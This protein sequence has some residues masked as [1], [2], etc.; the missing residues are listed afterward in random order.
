MSTSVSNNPT[1]SIGESL[2]PWRHWLAGASFVKMFWQRLAGIIFTWDPLSS[3]NLISLRRISAVMKYFGPEEPLMFEIE[4]LDWLVSV[5]L[6]EYLVAEFLELR[7][8]HWVWRDDTEFVLKSLLYTLCNCW[9]EFRELEVIKFLSGEIYHWL[10]FWL[11][12]CWA[13]RLK[14]SLF[15]T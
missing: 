10:V 11:W 12:F 1:T 6:C 9:S 3:R 4:V 7:V 14:V 13:G 8:R 2:Y 15:L 5:F